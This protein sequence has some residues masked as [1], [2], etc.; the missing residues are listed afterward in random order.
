[1]ENFLENDIKN[2]TFPQDEENDESDML[3]K[4]MQ[5]KDKSF[6][7]VFLDRLTDFAI[8]H[9]IFVMFLMHAKVKIIIIRI[10]NH[11]LLEIRWKTIYLLIHGHSSFKLLKLVR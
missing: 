10:L 9:F 5:W 1:V 8:A 7:E 3:E 2:A 11:I 6:K 4:L